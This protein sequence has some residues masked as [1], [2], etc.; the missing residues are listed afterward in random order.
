[1]RHRLILLF[2]ASLFFLSACL[3]RQTVVEKKPDP[4]SKPII[5]PPQYLKPIIGRVEWIEI[6]NWKLRIRARI[7]SGAK[8]CS[9]HAVNVEKKVENGET[10]VY[11]DTFNNEGKLFRVKSKYLNETKVVGTCGEAETRIVIRETLKLGKVS[12]EVNLTLNDR[13]N[14]TYPFLV[15]RNFLMGKFL[16]D[17]SLSHALGD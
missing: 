1:M 15:G 14:L 5:I 4:H 3:S 9:I 11:F 10:Y 8:T 16:V 17:V 12:E 7:D 6:P 2:L 13:T